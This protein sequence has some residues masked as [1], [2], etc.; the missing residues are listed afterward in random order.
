[1]KNFTETLT[2]YNKFHTRDKNNKPVVRWNRVVLRDVFC[3]RK[4]NMYTSSSGIF[5][6]STYEIIIPSNPKY[7]PPNYESWG[8]YS[9]LNKI[10][11]GYF[12]LNIDD[13]IILGECKIN[14][15]KVRVNDLLENRDYKNKSFTISS[16]DDNT[17]VDYKRYIRSNL[18]NAHY[19]VVG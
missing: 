7:M 3:S 13:V 15:N 8:L 16:V 5:S 4:K 14:M 17:F 12:T 1:M 9:N 2:L 18:R 6:Q 19:K 11:H 10:N